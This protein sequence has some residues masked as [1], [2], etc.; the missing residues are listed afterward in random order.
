[1]KFIIDAQLPKSLSEFLKYKGFDAIHT[2]D[3]PEKNGTSDTKIIS[4]ANLENR[5]VITKDVDFLESFLL[6]LQPNQLII[7]RTGN[8]HNSKLLDLFSINL[9]LIVQLMQ[10]S[11]LIEINNSE[12]IEHG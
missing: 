10:K 7:V 8:I 1:M 5:I 6:K 4:L 12:I 3:L 9:E 2:S 11:N